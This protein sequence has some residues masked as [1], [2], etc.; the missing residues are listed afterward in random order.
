MKKLPKAFSKYA[1]KK[2]C[3]RGIGFVA[4]A[5]AAA[6]NAQTT[7]TSS[8]QAYPA[9]VVRLLIPFSA[10]SGSDTIGR[11]YAGGLSDAFGQ[12]VIVENRAG[13]A[14][15]IGAEVAARAAPDGY[16]LLFVNIAHAVNVSMYRTLAYD[17]LRDFAPVSMI[18][19]G[20][21]MLVA[22]PSLPAKS[23]KE[24][25]ALAKAR[26]GA[27]QQAS[28]GVGTFTFL[29]AELF[30]R[31]AGIDMLHVPYRS[32]GEALTAV[33]S[34]ETSVYFAPVAGA[35][36]QVKQGRLRPL[37]VTSAKRMPL[38]PD[39]PTVADGGYPNFEFG[40]WYGIVVPVKTPREVIER[41]SSASN[42]ALKHAG[43]NKRLQESGFVVIGNSPETFGAYFRAEI[44]AWGKVVRELKL[45]AG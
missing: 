24:L 40:N 26:P 37:A 38:V 15:N 23:V 20:P 34:G 18:A 16:T 28:A 11:I 41:V 22:H 5:V 10:G 27:I 6:V 45:A 1:R 33:L 7:S 4:L 9:K 14:G 35:L 21:A 2:T 44:E 8:G 25:V 13:A 32:G 3:C 36:P 12:Q 30:K 31:R 29:A 39:V 43:L 19:T 42:T 17:P